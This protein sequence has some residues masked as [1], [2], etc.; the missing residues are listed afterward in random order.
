MTNNTQTDHLSSSI[1]RAQKAV[2]DFDALLNEVTG[3]LDVTPP[4]LKSSDS[5]Q[6]FFSRR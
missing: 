5:Q 4:Q 1:F 3:L 6:S 2:R